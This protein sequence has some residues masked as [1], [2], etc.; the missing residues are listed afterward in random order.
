RIAWRQRRTVALALAIDEIEFEFERHHWSKAVFGEV[1]QDLLERGARLARDGH[2]VFVAHGGEDLRAR[3]AAA[4]DARDCPGQR[5]GSAIGIAVA[6]A[7]AEGID[8]LALG[9][10]Q[11]DRLG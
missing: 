8:H 11:I 5:P 1:L 7:A 9:I 4:P 10:H 2:A 6:K 3:S